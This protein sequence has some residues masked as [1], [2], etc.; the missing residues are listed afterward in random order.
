MP[1]QIAAVPL[2]AFAEAAR[3]SCRAA[4]VHAVAVQIAQGLLDL[5]GW[6]DPAIPNPLLWR[7]MPAL[8]G[9]GPLPPRA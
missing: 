7:Q 9:M 4:S 1:A 5:E 8:P 6:R 3:L 2:A